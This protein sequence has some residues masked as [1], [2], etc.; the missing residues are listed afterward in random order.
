[1]RPSV[2]RPPRAEKKLLMVVAPP[3]SRWL[4][5]RDR[6]DVVAIASRRRKRANDV[7]VDDRLLARGLHV[8]DGDSP[9][10]VI[11]SCRFP[12]H[13]RTDVIDAAAR[14]LDAFADDRGEAGQREA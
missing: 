1:M 9:V 11:D 6:R 13:L 12:P 8:D 7:A 14:E 5:S 2:L 3:R 10:T 4:E